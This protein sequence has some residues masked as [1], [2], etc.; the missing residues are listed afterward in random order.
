MYCSPEIPCPSSFFSVSQSTLGG[1]WWEEQK[2]TASILGSRKQPPIGMEGS[3][4]HYNYSTLVKGRQKL[5]R[6]PKFKK[7]AVHRSA[8]LKWRQDLAP[9]LAATMPQR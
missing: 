7:T 1:I 9:I 6:K 4:I 3:I 2:S 5:I 8:I